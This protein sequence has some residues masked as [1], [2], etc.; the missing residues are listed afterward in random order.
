MFEM[1]YWSSIISALEKLPKEAI[2]AVAGSY[3]S[4]EIYRRHLAARI[5]LAEIEANANV[6]T[7]RLEKEALELE[8]KLENLRTNHQA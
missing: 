5:A 7:A 4:V 6:T 3:A 8:I 1:F 2:F